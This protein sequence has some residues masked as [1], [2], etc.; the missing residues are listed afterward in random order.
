[1]TRGFAFCHEKGGI[2][3]PESEPLQWDWRERASETKS[4]PRR[5]R[6]CCENDDDSAWMS[7]VA[8]AGRKTK[9]D[10]IEKDKNS[11]SRA[12][13]GY[14]PKEI[15]TPVLA[16]KGPRPSPLDDGGHVAKKLYLTK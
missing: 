16:L 14:A 2:I 1:M 10:A 13:Y 6:L 8:N 12:G 5:G 11:P 9:G 4:D 15:R 3:Q 7:E